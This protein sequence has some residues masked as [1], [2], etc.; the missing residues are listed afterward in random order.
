MAP[1]LEEKKNLDQL[2]QDG[3]LPKDFSSTYKEPKLINMFEPSEVAV[4][5]PCAFDNQVNLLSEAY[6][7]V[8]G[9]STNLL[10]SSNLIDIETPTK[11]T[12]L[13]IAARYGKDDIVNLVIERASKLL[14]K[15]NK[16]N[17]SALHVAARGG[18]FSTVKTL[19][20]CYTNI[21]RCDIKMAWL[22]YTNSSNDLEDYDE[23]LNMEDLLCFVNKENAQGNTMLHEAMLYR[24]IKRIGGDKIFKVCELY[25]IE[26]R[27]GNSLS[28]CCYGFALDIANLA[29]KSVI[30]LAVENG[31][32]DAV[33]LILENCPKNDAKPEGL[34]PVV[35]A[36]MKHNH[37]TL[38]IILLFN[39][40]NHKTISCK[41]S[42]LCLQDYI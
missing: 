39:H 16:N 3:V 40:L 21:E 27:F 38:I 25:K 22:E 30:Y 15:F 17:D 13:H 32:K 37:G 18:H 1:S 19:L 29:K 11:N 2:M 4:I 12:V 36:I 23:V 42:L 26:D 34:S 9:G 33:K 20:A 5:T 31:D 6:H 7:L 41:L 14:F 35:E 24:D 28:D 10:G 8:Y